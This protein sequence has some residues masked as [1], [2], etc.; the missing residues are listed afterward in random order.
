MITSNYAI[1]MKFF[2]TYGRSKTFTITNGDFLN[3]VNCNIDLGICFVDGVEY[4]EYL[5]SIK[6][7]IKEYIEKANK[8]S[9]NEGVNAIKFSE[10]MHELHTTY[11]NIINYVVIYSINGYDGNVQTITMNL[12]LSS[13][14][15]MYIIPEFL[16][17]NVEDIKITIL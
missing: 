10:L 16:T 12:D 4:S 15:N 14:Q 1:Y 2:N 9:E 3:R 13:D 5:D 17:I 11:A 6:L 8:I 7:T